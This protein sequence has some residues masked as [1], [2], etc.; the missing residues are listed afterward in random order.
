MSRYWLA[1]DDYREIPCRDGGHGT[2]PF[3][4]ACYLVPDPGNR[5]PFNIGE[6]GSSD[7]HTAMR[8]PITDNNY[9]SWHLY[10]SIF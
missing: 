3:S 2:V 7:Y 6:W 8:C 1:I 9:R 10:L 4:W 5:F